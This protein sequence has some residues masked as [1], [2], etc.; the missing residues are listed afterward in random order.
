MDDIASGDMA[1]LPVIVGY[2]PAERVGLIDNDGKLSRS[3]RGITGFSTRHQR[4]PGNYCDE[5]GK[6]HQ[7]PDTGL[8]RTME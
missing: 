1:L 3:H 8:V 5:T 4:R 6:H 2:A 7:A